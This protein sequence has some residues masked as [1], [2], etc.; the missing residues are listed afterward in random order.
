MSKLPVWNLFPLSFP[1]GESVCERLSSSSSERNHLQLIV[2]LTQGYF[3]HWHQIRLVRTIF[4]ICVRACNV[5]LSCKF[6]SSVI[7]IQRKSVKVISLFLASHGERKIH[8]FFGDGGCNHSF[9]YCNFRRRTCIL[10]Y[11]P[12][13]RREQI[14]H[15]CSGGESSRHFSL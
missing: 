12:S 11:G 13:I 2:G 14:I 1:S 4:I 3:V 6:V 7:S 10:T 9:A 5:A 15:E 8:G